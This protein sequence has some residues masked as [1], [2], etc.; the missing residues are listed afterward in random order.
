LEDLKQLTAEQ[1]SSAILWALLAESHWTVGSAHK[2]TV[3]AAQEAGIHCPTWSLPPNLEGNALFKAEQLE[4][5][6]T[7]YRNALAIFPRYAVPRFNLAMISMKRAEFKQAEADLSRLLEHHPHHPNAFLMRAQARLQIDE[8]DGALE[9]AQRAIA[10][11]PAQATA[12]LLLGQVL[13]KIGRT[14]EALTQYCKAKALGHAAG[15]KLC[16]AG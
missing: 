6:E 16:P 9:D 15:A 10:Q 3:A 11:D 8:L 4:A 2:A 12:Y 1:P 14:E 13:A 7:A 5:A